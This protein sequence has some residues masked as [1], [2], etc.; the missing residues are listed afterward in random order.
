MTLVKI[1]DSSKD[2]GIVPKR[3]GIYCNNIC[4][5]L[6]QHY[7]LWAQETDRPNTSFIHSMFMLGLL[8][9]TEYT[10]PI[11][12]RANGTIIQSQSS[13]YAIQY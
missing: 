8:A 9:F 4:V 7:H 12:C 11:S 6:K 10:F 3:L 2:F 5:S 1:N 13:P